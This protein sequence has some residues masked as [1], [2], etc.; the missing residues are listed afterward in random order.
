M[1]FEKLIALLDSQ[2]NWPDHY[3]FKFIGTCDHKEL[4]IEAVGHIP[5][6]EKPSSGGKYI[7]YTFRV[8]VSDTNEVIEIYKKV[9]TITG[10]ISL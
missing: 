10:I 2:Y 3:M 7:S 1:N 5:W 8:H 9:S 4:L 6:E